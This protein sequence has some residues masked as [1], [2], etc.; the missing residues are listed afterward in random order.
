[1][2]QPLFVFKKPLQE[3]AT[4]PLGSSRSLF[5]AQSLS[6]RELA[7]HSM[8]GTPDHTS[9]CCWLTPRFEVGSTSCSTTPCSLTHCVGEDL[10]GAASPCSSITSASS[11]SSSSA[12]RSC[13]QQHASP[14]QADVASADVPPMYSEPCEMQEQCEVQ[15]S[16]ETSASETARL[17]DELASSMHSAADRTRPLVTS[18]TEP[19]HTR[20]TSQELSDR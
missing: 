8:H 10:I 18:N 11:S 14:T 20:S 17:S 12:T 6:Q 2:K 3:A 1:V 7:M 16:C 4:L 9:S 5:N 15:E 13:D 19:L